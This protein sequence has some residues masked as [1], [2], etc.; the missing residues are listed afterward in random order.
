MK[1]IHQYQSRVNELIEHFSAAKQPLVI[2]GA[3]KGGWYLLQV[4]KY[5]DID[6]HGFIDNNES[7]WGSYEG[8]PVVSPKDYIAQVPDTEVVMGLFREKTVKQIQ[9]QLIELGYADVIDCLDAFLFAYF[10]QVVKRNCDMEILAQ[11]ISVLFE[12]Y[13]EERP[14]HYGYTKNG[15]FVSPFLTSNITQKCSL[16]CVDCVHLIPYYQSPVNYSAKSVYQ[17]IKQYAQAFDVVPEISI[18]GGEPLMNKEMA[19]ICDAISTIPNIVFVIFITNGTIVPSE[20]VVNA[21]A[22]NGASLQQSDYQELSPKN[23]AVTAVCRENNIFTDT[24]YTVE[25]Q[26]WYRRPEIKKYNRTAEENDNVYNGCIAQKICCHIMDGELHRCA[27]SIHAARLGKI[28][29][30]DDDFIELNAPEKSTE[31]LVSEIRTFFTRTT[32]LGACDHCISP[33]L[34]VKPALQLDK[35]KKVIRIKEA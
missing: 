19:D 29:K 7:I 18:S 27:H 6:V 8:Y 2:F 31:Q 21:L 3:G 33:T 28:P 4:L 20:K 5:F 11:S 26:M 24:V 30:Y 15:Y 9:P 12:S 25:S 14:D 22:R 17:D 35:R 1:K 23:R 34:Q 10:E 32:A 13:T 16:E